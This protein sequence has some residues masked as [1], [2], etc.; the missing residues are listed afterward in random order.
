MSVR[1]IGRIWQ[2]AQVNEVAVYIDGFNLYNGLKDKHGRKYLWL[3][4]ES[5]ARRLL[6]QDQQLAL[7]RYFTAPVRNDPLRPS[8]DKRRTWG[9]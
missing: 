8:G 6:R 2:A 7:V 4:L 5:L 1:D 9:C 3:D